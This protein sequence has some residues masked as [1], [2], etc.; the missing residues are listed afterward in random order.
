MCFSGGLFIAILT[1]ES[2]CCC[3]R[4]QLRPPVSAPTGCYIISPVWQGDLQAVCSCWVTHL[5]ASNFSTENRTRGR[6]VFALFQP[7]E[8]ER[9]RRER[10]GAKSRHAFRQD[11]ISQTSL[12]SYVRPQLLS[13]YGSEILLTDPF[14]VSSTRKMLRMTKGGK[15]RMNKEEQESAKHTL[16]LQILVTVWCLHVLINRIHCIQEVDKSRGK[17]RERGFECE[18]KRTHWWFQDSYWY[19]MRTRGNCVHGSS[20]Y[21]MR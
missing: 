2:V 9:E 21:G 19:P 18:R 6:E 17:E 16:F 15:K 4:H 13:V 5:K 11:V 10:E 1:L 7:S 8:T 3:I 14:D 20:E 12:H